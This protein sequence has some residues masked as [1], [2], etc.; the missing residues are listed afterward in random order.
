[1]AQ[2][3][4]ATPPGKVRTVAV[5]LPRM[6]L[7]DW[8]G[9]QSVY[10]QVYWQGRDDS[11]TYAGVG[12]ALE[13]TGNSQ[14][15]WAELT[16]FCAA[17]P[18]A[19]LFGGQRFSSEGTTGE[20]WRHFPACSFM[21]PE[22]LLV[23]DSEGVTL[24]C[25]MVPD[26]AGCTKDAPGRLPTTVDKLV[27]DVPHLDGRAIAHGAPGYV[28]GR[29]GWEAGV[30]SA[31]Q[32]MQDDDMEKVVLA[33]RMDIGLGEPVNPFTFVRDFREMPSP[34]YFFC[35]RPHPDSA[36]VGSSPESLYAR[37]GRQI[38]SE[39]LAG[40]RLR[41]GDAEEDR[42]LCTALLNAPKERHEHKLVADFIADALSTLCEASPQT[43]A[44]DVLQLVLVQHLLQT[45]E[46]SL[47]DGVKDGDIVG[48]LHPTPAVGGVPLD[49]ARLLIDSLE[50]FDRGWYAAPL[51]MVSR[52]HVD[53]TVAIR[54]GLLHGNTL[55]LYC[56]AGIVAES[57]PEQ[58]WQE[59]E[60]K[61]ANFMHVIHAESP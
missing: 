36:F 18:E 25:S 21:L 1:M 3:P 31:L 39:A 50:A 30:K 4:E 37:Y 52:D 40:T 2:R 59:T 57:D 20:E 47:A 22:F 48:A 44:P 53:L 58:E 41:G 54:S 6:D 33:R 13:F 26:E 12:S 61:L 9:A 56:G 14:Q 55:S 16:A 49:K 23:Q 28:P 27:F 10:P 7:L 43:S 17:H 29:Y 60:N 24:H 34:A 19:V 51:G 38:R 35:F 45:F 46:G 32:A 11:V 42:A 8:V 5:P 15:A